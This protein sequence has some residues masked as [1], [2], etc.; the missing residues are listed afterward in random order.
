[1]QNSLRSGVQR[2]L[3]IV[4]ADCGFRGR[5]FIEDNYT[6]TF[7][8]DHLYQNFFQQ[9]GLLP[10]KFTCHK[11]KKLLLLLQRFISLQTTQNIKVKDMDFGTS[12]LG[13]NSISAAIQLC[14]FN[15][16]TYPLSASDSSLVKRNGGGLI[17][18]PTIQSYYEN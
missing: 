14:K 12:F 6:M 13:L 3:V 18:V 5:S 1:M 17:I 9:Q 2:H 4:F 7:S 15:Q 11:A 16:V 8:V 10:K